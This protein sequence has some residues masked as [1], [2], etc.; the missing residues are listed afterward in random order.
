[1]K[2]IAFSLLETPKRVKVCGMQYGSRMSLAADPCWSA[3]YLPK[4]G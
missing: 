1:M 3:A 4:S 2:Q